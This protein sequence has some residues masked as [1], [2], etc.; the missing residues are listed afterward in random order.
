MVHTMN[1]YAAA[2]IHVPVGIVLVLSVPASLP[3]VALLH[4]GGELHETR[5]DCMIIGPLY[6]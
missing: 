6:Q 5:P 1:K 4:V 3:T 2:N